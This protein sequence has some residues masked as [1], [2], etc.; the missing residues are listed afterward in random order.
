VDLDLSCHGVDSKPFAPPWRGA[1]IAIHKPWGGPAG[2]ETS[3]FPANPLNL[4]RLVPA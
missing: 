2:P 1:N 3:V 4:I